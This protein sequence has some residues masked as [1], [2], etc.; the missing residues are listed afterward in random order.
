MLLLCHCLRKTKV[1]PRAELFGFPGP[2]REVPLQRFVPN[3][4]IIVPVEAALDLAP[5]ARKKP[6][7]YGQI[8]VPRRDI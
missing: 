1:S 6:R 8:R 2:F 3:G 4:E 7:T 5:Q